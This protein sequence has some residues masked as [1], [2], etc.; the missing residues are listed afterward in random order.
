MLCLELGRLA[1]EPPR[2]LLDRTPAPPPPSYAAAPSVSSEATTALLFPHSINRV[3]TLQRARVDVD[4]PDL[5]S[6]LALPCLELGHLA[7]EPTPG[8]DPI[9]RHRCDI[10][11]RF[12][13]NF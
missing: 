8:P 4:G 13:I 9:I 10:P 6:R 11:H 2:G 5:F 1:A 12:G 7:P 3:D